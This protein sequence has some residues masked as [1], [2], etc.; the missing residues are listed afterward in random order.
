MGEQS[1]LDEF[2]E[3][4]LQEIVA[5]SNAEQIYKEEALFDIFTDYLIDAGEFED[6]IYAHYQP[7]RG[8]IRIDGYCG[9]P[10]EDS[11]AREA[12]SAT[13]GVIVLDLGIEREKQTLTRTEINAAFK[14]IVNFV[15]KS[16]SQK[17]RDGMEES[18]PG[19]ELAD[20]IS[21]RWP[22]ISRVKV[23]LL[24]NKLLSSQA[25]SKEDTDLDGTQITYSVWD[26]ARLY[27]L[28]TSGR[29]RE[30][31]V[32]D[33][34]EL[35]SGPL[36][37]L[38]ASAKSGKNA[39]YLTAVPGLDLA[40]IYDRW[41]TR[42]LEQNVRVFLQARSKVNKGI[43]GTLENTPEMFFSFNNGLTAT[44]ERVE[45]DDTQE[46]TKIVRLDNFQI[47]NGGQ[48]T[49]SIYAAFKS[50]IDLSKVY[51]QMKLSIVSPAEAKELVPMISR[52]ANSQNRVSDADF[53]SNHPYHVRIEN[54]SRRI[55]A[56][57]QHGSYIETKWYYE[58]ARG[59]YRDE[60]AYLTPSKKKKFAEV[61]P[62][63]QSFTKT[64]LA[65]Y[66][67]VWTDD[68]YYVNRGAQKNFAQ[69]AK[70][71]T[72]EWEENQLQ[73]NEYYYRCLIAKKIIFNTTEKIVTERDWYEQGGYRAPHVVLTLGLLSH[74]VKSMDKAV[75]FEAIWNAQEIDEPFRRALG[76]AADAAH[77]VLMAPQAGYKN[78]TE[79][80]KQEKCLTELRKRDIAWDSE[81]IRTL[82]DLADEKAAKA[83]AKKDQKELNG[84]EAQEM[85][86]SKGAEFW[87]NVLTWAVANG[88]G[89]EREQSIMRVAAKMNTG[90]IPTD[91]Q[92]VVLT[93]MMDR[94]KH[95]GCPYRLR[96]GRRARS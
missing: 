37:A 35:P 93:E 45:T 40:T 36:K 86:V 61:Y 44:A 41:G 34:G 56:P 68:A 51:V 81:W 10:L 50:G 26:I 15:D 95:L 7:S 94:F 60:Q 46:G 32:V 91:K 79:W 9:D 16:R 14:R 18:S 77:E 43:K 24:T 54:F 23:Y 74:A 17:F 96:R 28:A 25:K 38:R 13:L 5:T 62:K 55:Y 80:A 65:K 39:V 73:F 89:T 72:S 21:E 31:L 64:D 71:I 88:E 70:Q 87:A 82:S 84:I 66:L 63:A 57:P 11:I 52:S 12:K 29:E 19:Y 6:A 22:I 33:F 69:F 78:I 83:E 30:A 67:M 49:A 27:R 4:F 92:S 76:Q 90:N 85:V 20:L 48:T 1:S 3:E 59:Q 8:G 58:R 2:Y 47:V 42:L 75:N 53:F